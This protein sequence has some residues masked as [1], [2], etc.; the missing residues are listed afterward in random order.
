V[1]F[2]FDGPNDRY[3]QSSQRTKSSCQFR[4]SYSPHNDISFASAKKQ[5]TN[6][7]RDVGNEEA[8]PAA[9]TPALTPDQKKRIDANR[10]QALAN[11]KATLA[12]KEAA[13]INSRQNHNH[14][15][16]QISPTQ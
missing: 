3:W 1:L 16:L 5:K 6:D 12:R 7:E 4:K 14:K 10:Q 15:P 11:L 9:I 13:P 2:L 8:K